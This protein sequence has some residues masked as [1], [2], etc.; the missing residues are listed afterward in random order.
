MKKYITA[1]DKYVG[2]TVVYVGECD[3][4]YFAFKDPLLTKPFSPEELEH[5][6]YNTQIVFGDG[7]DFDGTVVGVIYVPCTGMCPCAGEFNSVCVEL[8][9]IQPEFDGDDATLHV[10]YARVECLPSVISL[11]DINSVE[12][13]EMV[14]NIEINQEES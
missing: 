14:K 3:G 2:S 6:F 4:F 13:G 7:S 1:A 8:N 9:H 5:A 10:L 12:F 11:D